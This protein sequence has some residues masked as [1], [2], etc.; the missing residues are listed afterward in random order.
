MSASKILWKVGRVLIFEGNYGVK[1]RKF[2]TLFLNQN[3]LQNS[4]NWDILKYI[5]IIV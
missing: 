5:D 2:V 3:S 4:L 1:L